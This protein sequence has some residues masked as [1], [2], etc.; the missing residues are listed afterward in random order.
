M[1]STQKHAC[2]PGVI[3]TQNH[4]IVSCFMDRTNCD[5]VNQCQFKRGS[6][7]FNSVQF[8]HIDQCLLS[9]VVG[10]GQNVWYNN[11]IQTNGYIHKHRCTYSLSVC[12][13]DDAIFGFVLLIIWQKGAERTSFD[14]R[15]VSSAQ[16]ICVIGSKRK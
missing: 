6:I 8:H 4:A 10:L 13:F 16:Q 14:R 5:N 3:S 1:F 11:E 7:L 15:Y 12:V 2:F 9:S